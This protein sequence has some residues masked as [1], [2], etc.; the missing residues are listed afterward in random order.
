MKALISN[1]FPSTQKFLALKKCDYFFDPRREL[2]VG[3][4]PPPPESAV[5]QNGLFYRILTLAVPVA[6]KAKWLLLSSL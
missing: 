5:Q 2:M 4:H 3:L 1:P 6:L